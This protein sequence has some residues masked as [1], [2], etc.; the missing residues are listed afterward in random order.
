[1]E[2]HFRKSPSSFQVQD[3]F[4]TDDGAENT[5]APSMVMIFSFETTTNGAR[6]TCVTTFPSVQA[7]EELAK[8][9]M[10]EGMRSA[11]GQ[12]DGLLAE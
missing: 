6:M 12:L 8:M 7:M 3:G 10:E 9:G 4:A 5:Q 2:V 11:L 1:L